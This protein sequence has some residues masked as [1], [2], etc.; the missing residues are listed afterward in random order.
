MCAADRARTTIVVALIA[1]SMIGC[2]GSPDHL[3]G[4]V[5][6]EGDLPIE[7][8]TVRIQATAEATV[9]GPDGAFTLPASGFTQLVIYNI[10]GQ[11]VRELI[12]ENMTAGMHTTIWNG[13]DDRDNS[14]SSGIYFS[15]LTMGEKT[16]VGK[17][18]LVK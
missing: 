17:M 16:A 18:M 9:T 12:S 2:T 14:V 11:K 8:A 6:D 1:T 13:R 4:M 5:V 7:G 15:R 3:S 10:T